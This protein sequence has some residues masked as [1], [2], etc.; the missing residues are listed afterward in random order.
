[1][2]SV[3]GLTPV[4]ERGATAIGTHAWSAKGV[5]FDQI[6]RR[7]APRRRAMSRSASCDGPATGF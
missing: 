5:Q 3:T 7:P 6:D 2:V 4:C 1:M